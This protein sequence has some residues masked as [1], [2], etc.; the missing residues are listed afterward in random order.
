MGRQIGP[1]ERGSGL[2][3]RRGP[4]PHQSHRSP[5]SLPGLEH[6]P[7]KA[8]SKGRC[9]VSEFPQP[10]RLRSQAEL[11]H[12]SGPYSGGFSKRVRGCGAYPGKVRGGSS[13]PPKWEGREFRG[14][15]RCARGA[16]ARTEGDSGAG[17]PGAGRGGQAAATAAAT[18][19]CPAPAPAAAPAR[20]DPLGDPARPFT[21]GLP[22]GGRPGL[23]CSP[24]HLAGE[25][26][27]RGAAGWSRGLDLVLVVHPGP[28]S[29]TCRKLE[30][31]R[32]VWVTHMLWRG[33]PA[34]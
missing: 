27:P 15:N 8:T 29:S 19:P 33:V 14:T 10:A 18:P 13:E 3:T 22:P 16:R 30:S 34:G 1:P 4:I 26:D 11:R 9:L 28:R 17:S 31:R 6:R 23:Q 5:A 12:P 24:H 32:L 2:G 21:L 7:V 25:S 20:D